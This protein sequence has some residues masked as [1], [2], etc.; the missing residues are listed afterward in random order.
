M[1][2]LG[3]TVGADQ[4]NRNWK[5]ALQKINGKLLACDKKFLTLFDRV[6]Y[7][8]T[9]VLPK[10]YYMLLFEPPN[11]TDVKKIE[12][13]ICSF[14]WDYPSW[15]PISRD[16]L[17][18][19]QSEGGLNL[20]RLGFRTTA[21]FASLLRD[22]V[23]GNDPLQRKSWWGLVAYWIGFSPSKLQQLCPAGAANTVPHLFGVNK[24]AYFCMIL[25]AFRKIESVEP[26]VNWHKPKLKIVYKEL[27]AA[28]SKPVKCEQGEPTLDWPS[29]WFEV[30]HRTIP[31]TYRIIA[32]K[33]IHSALPFGS[34]FHNVTNACPICGKASADSAKHLFW[35][36]DA[37]KNV[38]SRIK[39]AVCGINIRV[40]WTWQTMLYNGAFCRGLTAKE[41][42]SLRILCSIYKAQLWFERCDISH[43]ATPGP[44]HVDAA[45]MDHKIATKFQTALNGL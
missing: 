35:E 41:A 26:S 6:R 29:V 13:C 17:G 20:H 12:K 7:V 3:V 1:T 32:F 11:K 39:R 38:R 34:C 19:P 27:I 2:V 44:R 36:C 18:R 42:C 25:E 4:H 9:Y 10:L 31:V 33:I 37:L 23:R 40:N 5:N 30:L 14:L 16:T 45:I 28:D 43:S 8:N 15:R 21:K 22:Y 24:N